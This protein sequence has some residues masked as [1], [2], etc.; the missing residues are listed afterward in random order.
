M[1]HAPERESGLTG[2][3][4]NGGATGSYWC[5]LDHTSH[6]QYGNASAVGYGITNAAVE[7]VTAVF[8]LTGLTPGTEY[9]FDWGAFV[10]SEGIANGVLCIVGAVGVPATD[11]FAG[12][13]TMEV[14]SA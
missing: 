11:L 7:G 6:A 4:G 8:Y 10:S 14:W 5:L 3:T 12:P 13:A 2:I 9:Q 1:Y